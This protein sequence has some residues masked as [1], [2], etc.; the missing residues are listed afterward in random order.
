MTLSLL[1][2][3]A[4][5]LSIY[6]DFAHLSLTSNFLKNL[7]KLSRATVFFETG[8]YHGN[9]TRQ[10]SKYFSKVITIEFMKEIFEK[11]NFS[12]NKNIQAYCGDSPAV[13]ERL[14]PTL[15]NEKIVF[16]LDA[17][18]MPRKDENGS[19]IKNSSKTAILEELAIIK[20]CNINHSIILIDDIPCFDGVMKHY[21]SIV[22]LRNAILQI[23]PAYNVEI[24]GECML[25]YLSDESFKVSPFIHACTISR[26]GSRIYSAK[27][28]EDA[29]KMIGKIS[30]PELEALN[31]IFN[32]TSIYPWILSGYSY[33]YFWQGL[34]FFQSQHYSHAEQ[35]F[36]WALRNQFP[37]RR[38]LN[39]LKLS[40]GGV[41]TPLKFSLLSLFRRSVRKAR[42]IY[43]KA[44]QSDFVLY[45]IKKLLKM[46][47]F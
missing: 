6:K 39:Y 34:V 15:Q 11:N 21:C 40:A 32:S 8:T 29:D 12:K 13:M 19:D 17:H 25:A 37:S 24:Y 38:I 7:A 45:K 14:L 16:W 10:A 26:F 36:D 28:V 3:H 4:L 23:N 35:Y 31:A 42:Y 1:K 30:G 20:K 5:E 46:N 33:F 44:T 41:N 2:K 27:E 47:V 18:G 22:D 9:T 43:Y